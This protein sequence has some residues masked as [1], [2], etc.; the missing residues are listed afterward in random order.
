MV[1]RVLLDMT[2][3]TWT[4]K[5]KKMDKLDFFKNVTLLSW[6]YYGQRIK[7]QP[8]NSLISTIWRYNNAIRKMIKRLK[9]HQRR[10]TDGQQ[11]WRDVQYH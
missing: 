7:G 11:T 2:P 8:P 4:I 3:K 6:K 5:E 10:Y 9:L 1:S